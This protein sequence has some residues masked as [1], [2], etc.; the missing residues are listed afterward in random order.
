MR[1]R[2][3]SARLFPACLLACLLLVACEAPPPRVH[4][5]SGQT[6]G[7]FWSVQ[8]ANLPA[9]M[10]LQQLRAAI[11]DELELVNRQMSTYRD[12]ADITRFNRAAAGETLTLPEDF[13]LVLVDALALAADTGGG[14]DPTVGPLVNLWGFG[15][16]GVRSQAPAREDIEAARARVGWQRLRFDPQTRALTQPGGVYLDLSSIAK[17]HAVD[18]VAE[19]L[20]ILGIDGYLVDI[21]GDLRA[22][23]VKP[24][25]SAWRIGVERPIP[26]TREIHTIIEVQDIAV[27]SSGDYRNLFVADERH[28]SHTIDPRTGYPVTDELGSVTVLH[29]S[30]RQADA[31]AT[32]LSVLGLTEGYAF[33]QDRNLAVLFLVREEGELRERMTAEF[34]R[35]ASEEAR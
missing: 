23:G 33:A 2:A 17:G 31:L 14:Y 27:A 9:G 24:D 22:G 11:E 1:R 3:G 29:A 25:G 30:A 26:G 20:Q 8:T 35:L 6:M 32:A 7:T 34:L 10:S 12:D 18:R 21:G 13:A 5:L 15:P 19:R 28:Y 4:A 16:D